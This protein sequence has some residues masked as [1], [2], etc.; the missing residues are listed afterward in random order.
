MRVQCRRHQSW[1]AWTLGIAVEPTSWQ[2]YRTGWAVTFWFGRRGLTALV[3]RHEPAL[4]ALLA[5]RK[6]RRDSL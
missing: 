6:V 5:D 1:E 2:L 4:R 3:T